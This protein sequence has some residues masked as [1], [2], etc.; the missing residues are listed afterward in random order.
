MLVVE[1]KWRLPLLVWDARGA[2]LENVVDGEK[3]GSDGEGRRRQTPARGR[4][5]HLWCHM[6]VAH[7]QQT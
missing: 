5:T 7:T 2:M 4:R 3:N 6:R 1:V